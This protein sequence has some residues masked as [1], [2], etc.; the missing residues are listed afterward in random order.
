[1]VERASL[2][3]AAALLL[4]GEVIFIAAGVL[5]PAREPANVHAAVFAEY[6]ASANWTAVHLGQFIGAA[7]IL[8]GLIVLYFALNVQPWGARWLARCAAVSAI[9]SIG[10]T[11]VLQA[12]DGVALKQAVDAWATAP[13]GEQ[14]AKFASAELIRWVEWATRSYQ[15][16][17]LGAMFLLFGIAI[18]WA[19][20]IPRFLGYLAILVGLAHVSQAWIVGSEG[21]SAANSIPNLAGLVLELVWIVGMVVVAARMKAPPDSTAPAGRDAVDVASLAP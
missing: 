1:M 20:G 2:R 17:M 11:A 14:T 4:V 6:A 3:L 8:F 15:Y 19:G 12:V 21:F 9:V 16:L 7:L 10:L 13:A 5:H 18:A